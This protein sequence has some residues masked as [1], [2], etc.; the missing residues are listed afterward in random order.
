M[1]RAFLQTGVLFIVN[2]ECTSLIT[3]SR[4]N[5]Y[6]HKLRFFPKVQLLLTLHLFFLWSNIYTTFYYIFE[7]GHFQ[8]M[9]KENV[10]I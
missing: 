9:K 1:I 5:L 3:S 7:S 2:F 6:D 10:G 4:V 8:I